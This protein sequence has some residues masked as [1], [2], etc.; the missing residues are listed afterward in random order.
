MAVALAGGGLA[1]A[2]QAREPSTIAQAP[3]APACAPMR[4]APP[5]AT[6]P[7]EPVWGY[8]GTGGKLYVI[9]GSPYLL[10]MFTELMLG[11]STDRIPAL[12]A[13]SFLASTRVTPYVAQIDATTMRVRVLRLTGGSEEIPR[14]R[15]TQ[16][17]PPR[18]PLTPPPP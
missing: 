1:A 5:S 14:R 4:A 17:S 6:L 15:S 9:G 7:E 16:R 12:T 13:R 2:S 11:A 18:E 8:A 10:N 3:S